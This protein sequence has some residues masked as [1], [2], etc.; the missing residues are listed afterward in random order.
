MRRI[1]AFIS[2]M[3][4]VLFGG[5]LQGQAQLAISAAADEAVPGWQKMASPDGDR[6]VW[7]A[8]T[9]SLTSANIQ[10]ATPSADRNGQP[11][12]AIVFTDA[13]ATKMRELSAAQNNKL[14]A[15]VMDGKVIWAPKVRGEIGKDAMITGGGQNGL[16]AEDSQRILASI[17]RP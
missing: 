1:S 12:I 10:R 2:V 15:M 6:S 9:P 17:N 8:P 5:A 13:G 7:V 11:A 14:I 4:F 16:S 3:V